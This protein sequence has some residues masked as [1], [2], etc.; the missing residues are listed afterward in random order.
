MALF[1]SHPEIIDASSLQAA[2]A[3]D[4]NRI[5]DALV[6]LV[7]ERDSLKEELTSVT[8]D[9]KNTRL[10]HKASSKQYA[11]LFK[12]SG[13]KQ[14]YLWKWFRQM[15]N[16]PSWLP[17]PPLSQPSEAD[18]REQLASLPTTWNREVFM[19]RW[20]IEGFSGEDS[21]ETTEDGSGNGCEHG[22]ERG[23]EG[24]TDEGTEGS[25]SSAEGSIGSKAL[26]PHAQVFIPHTSSR[27]S[28]RSPV[29]RNKSPPK[30]HGTPPR[31]KSSPRKLPESSRIEYSPTPRPARAANTFT[32]PFP[33][34]VHAPDAF[35]AWPPPNV[36]AYQQT[37]PRLIL[38]NSFPDAAT[39]SLIVSLSPRW[40]AICPHSLVTFPARCPRAGH[41]RLKPVCDAFNEIGGLGC[42]SQVGTCPFPHE[43]KMCAEQ[44][45][46]VAGGCTMQY[47]NGVEWVSLSDEQFRAQIVAHLRCRAHQATC[48]PE[49][50]KQRMIVISLRDAHQM[51]TYN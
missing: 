20:I 40:M 18:L 39:Q 17:P 31:F 37:I 3:L 38:P 1:P 25:L 8:D 9:L 14:L 24:G 11:E 2:I 32:S 49:E 33:L 35:I 43:R 47:R 26:D 15:C 28:N 34:A 45:L 13:A 12:N 19:E 41:C 50:W 42:D 6:R 10:D 48:H 21:W 36:F 27:V 7:K 16:T 5:F 51:G 44:A 22:T 46:G 23:T 4:S 30:F 29:Q